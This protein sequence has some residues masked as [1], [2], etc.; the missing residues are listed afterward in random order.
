ML[1]RCYNLVPEDRVRLLA[2]HRVHQK[3]HDALVDMINQRLLHS[4]R[5]SPDSATTSASLQLKAYTSLT[6]ESIG[7]LVYD[8]PTHRIVARLEPRDFI[9]RFEVT[10][11]VEYL[12]ALLFP[13][14][15]VVIVQEFALEYGAHQLVLRT[16]G[17][18]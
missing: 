2:V 1:S 14:V 9:F 18:I 7:I 12:L 10:E 17:T 16:S 5:W 15:L 6:F 8:R 11:G 4:P 13:Q 3:F